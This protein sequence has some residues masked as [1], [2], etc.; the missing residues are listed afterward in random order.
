[1]MQVERAAQNLR[2]E[3]LALLEEKARRQ[4][5]RSLA[6]FIRQAWAIVEPVAPY[7]H[8]WHIDAIAEH[9]QAVTRGE[10]A[11][12]L[13]NIPPGC[14]KSYI[15]SVFWPAWEWATDASRRYLCVSFDQGLSTRDA[16][17]VR[18]LVTSEWYQERW[19]HVQLAN[20][21][22]QKM[23]FDTTDGG[24]RI[25]STMRGKALGE[26]PHRK[27]VDDPHNT[28]EVTSEVERQAAIDFFDQTLSTRGAA[29]HAAT[30]VIMQ[31][32]H[33]QDLSG[34]ILA[35][36]TPFVH[37]CLPMRFEPK[38][39]PATPLGWNDPRRHAG[40]LLW[41][42][43]FS[44]ATVASLET[45]L[46]SYGAAGQL[47]QRPAP[48]EGGLIKRHWWK[49]Y[50][51][52]P[53]LDEIVLSWDTALK[54]TQMADYSVGQ[55]W[56]RKGADR[57]LLRSVRERWGFVELKQQVKDLY[58]WAREQWPGLAIT[59]IIENAAAG[60][61]VI[62]ALRRDIPGILA[63]RPKGD[64]VQRVHAVLPAIEAGNVWVSGA[65]HPDGKGCDAA[66]TP[67]WVQDFLTECASFPNGAHDD[68]VDAC[69]QALLRF[70]SP[71]ERVGA[72]RFEHLL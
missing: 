36:G 4:A 69:S 41:P 43:M 5:E 55:A 19:P 60:P 32:L 1:M 51:A 62:A 8:T 59:V 31:R 11:N 65:P 21:Q 61:D 39:M 28:K 72:A 52:L 20:D 38:R 50:A 64:K 33:E 17:R 66:R 67:A 6:S 12:L 18:E 46:G 45:K 3:Y 30:V 7:C 25:A 48:A 57:Y 22:N 47:Q 13:I 54:D 63:V 27:I 2:L 44:E 23:R 71:S 15:V 70:Q 37:L 14:M 58:R 29:L 35:G 42:E 10:I 26:H 34:H 49:F 53:A 40:E 24:W 16:R 56:G 9:L 68:Q